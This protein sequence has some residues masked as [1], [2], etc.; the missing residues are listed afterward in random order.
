MVLRSFDPVLNAGEKPGRSG[1]K[2]A[3]VSLDWKTNCAETGYRIR[4]A[5]VESEGS[6][7]TVF[8]FLDHYLTNQICKN[9]WIQKGPAI[10]IFTWF[11][12]PVLPNSG[13][14]SISLYT[15]VLDIPLPGL[16]DH[17]LPVLNHD[18]TDH[19]TKTNGVL[20][21]RNS[22]GMDSVTTVWHNQGR[23]QRTGGLSSLSQRPSPLEPDKMK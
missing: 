17:A 19:D 21:Q 22:S 7:V 16:L 13:T 4:D 1:K 2:P 12:T 18:R 6:T 23:S 20:V 14:L 15:P 10:G 5:L 3:E 9:I 11:N 8:F